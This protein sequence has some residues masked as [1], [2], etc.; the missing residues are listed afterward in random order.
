MEGGAEGEPDGEGDP[1][2]LSEVAGEGGDEL[3]D[4]QEGG[5]EDAEGGERAG[6]ETAL[7]QKERDAGG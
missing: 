1:F 3:H 2:S 7:D 5:D 4:Q 6:A